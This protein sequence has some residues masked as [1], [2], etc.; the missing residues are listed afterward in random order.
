VGTGVGFSHEGLVLGPDTT[1]EMRVASPLLGEHVSMEGLREVWAVNGGILGAEGLPYAP[2][3][4]AH[5]EAFSPAYT[6]WG[7]PAG[8]EYVHHICYWVDDVEAESEQLLD[9]GFAVELT[10]YP[11]D[12][13][14][15]FGYHLS[16]S[17]MRIE[18]LDRASKA[19]HG[20]W[21]ATGELELNWVG[22]S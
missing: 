4:L 19:A 7:C 18:L 22:A 21:F 1:V 20:T 14:R 10:T 12:K 11:G 6:I 16:P 15:G 3:E 8:R 13:A 2:L 9:H 17:G 5:A